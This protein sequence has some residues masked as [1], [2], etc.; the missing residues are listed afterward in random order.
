MSAG[1][2]PP[3]RQL[4]VTSE[5]RRLAA[6]DVAMI[7]RI[8]RSEHVDIEYAVVAGALT[9]RPVTMV[10]IPPWDPTGT[11]PHSIAA[12]IEFCRP[13]IAA[14][15]VLLGVFGN[16]QPIG[17]AVVEPTFEPELA[18]LAWLHV[19]RRY[20]RCGVAQALWTAATDIARLAEARSIYVSA[21]PTGSAVGFYLRQGCR[22]AD[23]AHPTLIANEPDDIHLV[24]PLD[25][26]RVHPTAGPFGSPRAPSVTA[27]TIALRGSG[28]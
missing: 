12:Q 11:G 21:T 3:P 24:C 5:V 15:A 6:D 1:P 18:W 27:G 28:R 10:E 25:E 17:L 9:E 8:D 22:L 2:L 4:A 13:L 26:P 20:R 16:G 7:A 19:T 23:P 14:G